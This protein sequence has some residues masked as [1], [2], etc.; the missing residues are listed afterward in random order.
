QGT[1]SGSTYYQASRTAVVGSPTTFSTAVDGYIASF[2]TDAGDP[3]KLLI[4]SGNW[5]CSLYFV[6]STNTGSPR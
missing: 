3:N 2:I 5:N 1:F 6:A 4:P